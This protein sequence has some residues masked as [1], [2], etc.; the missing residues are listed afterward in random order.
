MEPLASTGMRTHL[1]AQYLS[2]WCLGLWHR[3]STAHAS[4]CTES[5]QL[6]CQNVLNTRTAWGP[7]SFMAHEHAHDRLNDITTR[8]GLPMTV[9]CTNQ[10]LSTSAHCSHLRKAFGKHI[11]HCCFAEARRAMHQH[12][13]PWVL[14]QLPDLVELR[15]QL[16]KA[17]L[18]VDRRW[19]RLLQTACRVRQGCQVPHHATADT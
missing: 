5:S 3:M 8:E 4:V 2:P 12:A 6:A 7:S 13:C 17:L 15:G 1:T 19:R 9:V 10:L 14:Q 16:I 11:C 18:G